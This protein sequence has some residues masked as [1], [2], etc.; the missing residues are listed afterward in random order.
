MTESEIGKLIDGSAESF[1]EHC[2]DKDLGY[3]N[4]LRNH[5]AGTYQMF[6]KMKDDLIKKVKEQ[7]LS[8]DSEECNTIK[9]I[10]SEMMK[11][12]E[13]AVL[14]VEIAKERELKD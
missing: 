8:E 4:S 2:S 6:V 13:K 11:V 14:C 7:K 1:R 3:V 10:Y 12:E 5:L 9:K